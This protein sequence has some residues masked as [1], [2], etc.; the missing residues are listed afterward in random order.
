MD[1]SMHVFL[2]PATMHFQMT[3]DQNRA[4]ERQEEQ[5]DNHLAYEYEP[6]TYDISD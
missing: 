6:R 3:M 1:S 5:L 4:N 2:T